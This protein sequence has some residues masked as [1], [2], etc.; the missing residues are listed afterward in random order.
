MNKKDIKLEIK[1]ELIS[2]KLLCDEYLA[3][4]W[5]NDYLEEK[6]KI[7]ALTWVLELFGDQNE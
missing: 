5:A 3:K 2:S 1:Q 6:A 7:K 4:G